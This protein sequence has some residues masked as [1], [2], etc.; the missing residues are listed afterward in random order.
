MILQV[1]FRQ[2][3]NIAPRLLDAGNA[4]LLRFQCHM[5]LLSDAHSLEDTH[6]KTNVPA[7]VEFL[8]KPF[9]A[10]YVLFASFSSEEA[11]S[12]QRLFD[13]QRWQCSLPS[14]FEI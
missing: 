9:S 11:S 12:H 3:Y 4:E 8:S 5:T 10:G 1:S 2:N 7:L 14:D 13:F 6:W